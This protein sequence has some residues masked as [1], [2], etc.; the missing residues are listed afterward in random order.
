MWIYGDKNITTVE[1]FPVGTVGFIYE[2]RNL[3][4]GKKYI[5]RKILTSTRKL[6]PLKGAKRKRTVVKD[7]GWLEYTGSSDELNADIA[8]GHQIEKHILQLCFSKKQMSYYELKYQ[9][10]YQVLESDKYYNG[11]I[12]GKYHRRDLIKLN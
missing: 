1:D 2:I 6:K 4:N 9:M 7:S 12:A 8:S 5:G 3:T 11:N 10:I